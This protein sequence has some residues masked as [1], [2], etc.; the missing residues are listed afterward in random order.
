MAK[1]EELQETIID[2]SGC[3]LGRLSSIV[4]KRL[5]RGERII[6]VNAEKAVISGNKRW[7]IEE[8]KQRL[9]RKTLTA[10]WRGPF[11]P[12]RPDLILKR[13]IRG[14]LPYDKFKGREA[15]KRLRVFIG[16][17]EKYSNSQ[18]EKIENA[19]MK[20]LRGPY[21]SLAELSAELGFKIE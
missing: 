19:K 5:L 9:E 21:I 18:F 14:M 2:A 16:V 13:T 3:L 17:P 10:P 6:I 8:Y 15:Y 20:N 7:I 12:R 4:A 1:K 11:Q